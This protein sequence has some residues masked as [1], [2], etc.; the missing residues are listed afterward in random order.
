MFLLLFIALLLP[1]PRAAAAPSDQ[2][3]AALSRGV[4]L[5]PVANMYAKPT[6]DAD[7]VS[8]A[9]YASH[10]NVVEDQ[11]EWVKVNTPDDYSGWM[12]AAAIRR[13]GEAERAY[14]SSGRVGEVRSLF[15]HL[16]REPDVTKH[17]PL[18]TVPFETRLEIVREGAGGPR[19]L[20]ARLPD[21]RTAWVQRGDLEFDPQPLTIAQTLALARRFLGL[22]YTWG[23]TSAY[24]YDCSGFMQM[25]ERV[26]GVVMPRDAGDQAAWSG[27]KRLW[28]K[29][30]RPGDLLYFGS[31]P[32]RITHTGM[33][34]GGGFFIHATTYQHPVVQIS[35]LRDAHWTRLLVAARRVKS[36]AKA[37]TAGGT[38]SFEWRAKSRGVAFLYKRRLS[39]L[40]T[41]ESSPGLSV[42]GYEEGRA[43]SRRDG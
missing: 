24:G 35:R 23:G 11:G 17:A 30:L 39:P 19:W 2:A 8:Q 37:Q 25:L 10:L 27:M 20:Q 33:Y 38:T 1:A 43:Q 42:L 41:I 34:I 15:C 9:I 36:T 29:E 32:K 26:R 31:S 7:V 22:P 4:V 40:G 14:A 16:Y 12:R 21:D 6:E 18:L 3:K 28:Y 13:Y 5:Q